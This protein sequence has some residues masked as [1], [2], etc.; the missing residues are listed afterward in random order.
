MHIYNSN[1]S[2]TSNTYDNNN[3]NNSNTSNTIN[4]KLCNSYPCPCPKLIHCSK[5][6]VDLTYV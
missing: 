3:S 1:G 5:P 6:C 4:N 2:N